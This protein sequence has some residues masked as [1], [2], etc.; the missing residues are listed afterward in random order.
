[1]PDD[2]IHWTGTLLH[3]FDIAGDDANVTYENF[4]ALVQPDDRAE[5]ENETEAQIANG[6]DES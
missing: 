4:I 5:L 3:I 2:E 6:P 1:M